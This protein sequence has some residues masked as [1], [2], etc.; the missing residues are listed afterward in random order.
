MSPTQPP[1]DEPAAAASQ[2]RPRNVV[3]IGYRGSGKSSVAREL[4]RRLRWIHVDTDEH[5]ASTAQRSIRDI[6]DQLGETAFRR[7]EHDA[8]VTIGRGTGQVI[9]VGGGGVL[10]EA[11]RDALRSAGL[12]VWLTA[13]P[14]ALHR[15][16]LADPHNQA[17]RPALTDRDALDEVRHLLHERE[18]LYAALADYV[19]ETAERSVMQ[20]TDDVLTALSEGEAP[21]GTP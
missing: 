21:S 18:P 11:N 5:I 2:R 9:S 10:S 7:F 19:I 4:A 16:M 1:T 14:E 15:R 3:L 20:V 8:I 17:T 12:C 13:P 6:F